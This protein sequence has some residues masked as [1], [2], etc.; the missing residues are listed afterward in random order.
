MISVH[1]KF[2]DKTEEGVDCDREC[3]LTEEIKEQRNNEEWRVSNAE[4]N[5]L[6]S[7]NESNKNRLQK[8]FVNP[9]LLWFKN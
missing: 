5:D 1:K 2:I 8:V 3:N 6:C 7:F 9:V 4:M